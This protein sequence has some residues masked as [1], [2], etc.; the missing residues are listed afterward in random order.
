MTRLS[1][2]IC[3]V[4]IIKCYLAGKNVSNQIVSIDLKF[5]CFPYIICIMQGFRQA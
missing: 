1:E 3:V 2:N 5:E 4:G